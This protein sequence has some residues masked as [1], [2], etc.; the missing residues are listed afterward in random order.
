MS[1]VVS[2]NTR[3]ILFHSLAVVEGRTEALTDA[4]AISLAAGDR[5]AQSSARA[6]TAAMVLLTMLVE[7]AKHLVQGQPPQALESYRAEHRLHGIGGR[8]YSRFGDALIPALRDTMGTGFPRSV[9][10]AWCDAFWAVV[11]QMQR[12]DEPVP[13]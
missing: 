11:G 9:A 1:T 4:L 13:A 5:G 2:D 12:H 10:S 6:A 8:D 7:Q 3:N